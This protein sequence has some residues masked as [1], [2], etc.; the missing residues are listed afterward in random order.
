MNGRGRVGE[1]TFGA[2]VCAA[3]GVCAVVA[4]RARKERLERVAIA[5]CGAVGGDKPCFFGEFVGHKDKPLVH[6]ANCSRSAFDE[7]HHTNR[8]PT[9]ITTQIIKNLSTTTTATTTMDP[10]CGSLWMMLCVLTWRY[11][12]VCLRLNCWCGFTCGC[13]RVCACM[14]AR[15]RLRA[16]PANTQRQTPHY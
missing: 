1:K 7:T 2:R 12:Q 14:G 10:K 16:M 4:V 3:I 9:A 15:V 6:F 11:T 5:F 8:W 13:K